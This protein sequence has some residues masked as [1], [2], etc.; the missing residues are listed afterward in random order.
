MS[1]NNNPIAN[2]DSAK[3]NEDKFVIIKPLANDKDIDKDK[4]T[5]TEANAENGTVVIN[6]NGTL[7]YTPNANFN[8]ED[9]IFYT[10]SDGKGGESTAEVMVTVKAV[11]DLPTLAAQTVEAVEDRALNITLLE[12][13]TDVDGDTLTITKATA[14]H[15]TVVINKDGTVTYTPKANYNGKDTISYTVSD[16]H[17]VKSSTVKVTEMKKQSIFDQ[18]FQPKHQSRTIH[19]FYI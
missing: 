3:T 11:N 14:A 10:V 2:N 18:K 13:L 16:G 5:I 12:D 15:G 19:K 8:G 1:V 6:S 9:T 4:L 7:K 17:A